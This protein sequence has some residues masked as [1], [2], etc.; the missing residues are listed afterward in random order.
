MSLQTFFD[1]F[2]NECTPVGT[3]DFQWSATGVG[4]GGMYFYFDEKD[5]YV[6]CSNEI[7]GREFIKKMLCQMV[8][9]C[10]LDCP[11]QWDVEAEGKP[12]GYTPKPVVKTD[13]TGD[14]G[15]ID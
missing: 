5:G 6:H 12:P 9:N 2:G 14:N 7:M 10:V 1:S 11:G 3:A 8:D 13:P 15:G 4:F